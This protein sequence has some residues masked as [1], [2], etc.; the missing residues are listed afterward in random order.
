MK[1]IV[2]SLLVGLGFGLICISLKLPLPAPKVFAGVAGI[3]G[4]WFAQPVW[5]TISKFIS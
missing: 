1:D 5:A 2:I 4:I 3:I